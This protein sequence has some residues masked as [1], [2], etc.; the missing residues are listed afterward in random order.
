MY[1][2]DIF[3]LILGACIGSFL[4]VCIYRIPRRESVAGKPSHCR[5]C[6]RR[7]KAR[8][9]VPVLSFLLLRG[10][11]RHCGG[12]IS[13]QYPLVELCTAALFLAAYRYWGWQWQTVSMWIFFAVLVTAAVIDLQH[14]IIPGEILVAGCALGLPVIFFISLS[15]LTG[16]ILG[17]F[18]AGLLLLVIALV[19][20]GGMGGGDIKLGAVMGLFLGWQG[21]IVALFI[22]FLVSGLAAIVLLATGRKGRKDAVPFGPYLALGGITAAFY[23]DWIIN[24]YLRISGISI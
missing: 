24:W 12:K 6:G 23:A 18:A 9:L 22:A 19:S 20:K 5:S 14:T 3:V 8:D 16:G 13:L 15:K 21:V 4:N 17:F 10:R 2:A 11:C 1:W 7:I